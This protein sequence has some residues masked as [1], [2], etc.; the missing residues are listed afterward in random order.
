MK[1]PA[2]NQLEWSVFAA[3]AVLIVVVIGA[4]AYFEVT[5]PDTPP[6]LQVRTMST[7]GS[8]G[9]FAVRVEVENRGGETAENARV[10][11]ELA[12]DGA[13][14]RSELLLAFVPRGGVRRGEVL[15]TKDPAQGR[16]LARV[17][18]YETP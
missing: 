16:L 9:G 2:K 8:A 14:E 7:R 10:E 13:S 15:F 17:V 12:L 18:G 5:R 1:T 4:L 6:E 11:V 3:S